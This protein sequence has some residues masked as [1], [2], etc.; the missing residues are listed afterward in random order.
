MAERKPTTPGEVLYFVM[1]THEI[2][3][4]KLAATM[5]VSRFRVNELVNG[6][7]AFT[8]ETAVLLGKALGSSPEFWMNLQIHV[9]LFNARKSLGRASDKVRCLVPLMAV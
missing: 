3:Q 7:R 9:D 4:D 6:K 5:G 8:P 1:K 2:T